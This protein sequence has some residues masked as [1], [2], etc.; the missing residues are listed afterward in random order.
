EVIAE[1]LPRI[2]HVQLDISDF[3]TRRTPGGDLAEAL[4]MRDAFPES[5]VETIAPVRVCAVDVTL[6]A[7]A[8]DRVRN[9]QAFATECSNWDKRLLMFR[10]SYSLAMMPYLS[11]SFGYAYYVPASPV[12]LT[13]LHELVREHDPDI[14]IEQRA[15]RW[16]RTPEG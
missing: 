5:A 10:D 12:S 7:S 14:V 9:Q 16:L 11:E 13:T 4:N 1:R 3:R 8:D 6:R 15:N 2:G